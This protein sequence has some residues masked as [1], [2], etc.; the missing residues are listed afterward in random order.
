MPEKHGTHAHYSAGCRC[1]SCREAHRVRA[2]GYRLRKANGEVVPQFRYADQQEPDLLADRPTSAPGPVEVSVQ[3]EIGDVVDSRP[4]LAQVAL[5]M[6]RLL[7]NP[8]AVN[9]QP[10]AAKVLVTVLDTLRKGSAQGRRGN[11]ALVKSM[12]TSSPSA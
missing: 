1:D 3:A 7:D 8:K 5:A 9:Q 11:L 4:G 12:T 2:R 6:A 10:A